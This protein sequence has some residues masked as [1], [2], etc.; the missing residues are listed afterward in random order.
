MVK[1]KDCISIVKS[2][3]TRKDH[4]D[5]SKRSDIDIYICNS[6]GGKRDGRKMEKTEIE[7]KEEVECESF[8]HIT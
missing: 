5:P 1:C 4:V 7:I 8:I 6:M 2:V 3:H